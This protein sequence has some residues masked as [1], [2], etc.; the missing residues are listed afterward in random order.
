MV[1][2]RKETQSSSKVTPP[3][4][5]CPPSQVLHGAEQPHLPDAVRCGRQRGPHPHRRPRE[6]HGAGPPGR[7]LLPGGP[8]GG[9]R[10]G[11]HAGHRQPLLH[12]RGEMEG[13]EGDGRREGWMEGGWMDV[14]AF[15]AH[16][17]LDTED[18]AS[19]RGLPHPLPADSVFF[20]PP[21]CVTD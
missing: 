19:T 10:R 14:R 9:V 17:T 8:A 15:K 12:L 5:V 20:R 1:L 16:W 18:T 4:P 6:G 21:Q 11:R 3:L 13:L 7:P 2:L